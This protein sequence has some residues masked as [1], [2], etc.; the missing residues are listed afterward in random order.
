MSVLEET[1][2]SVGAAIADGSLDPKVSAGPIAALR[3]LA[4]Q[5]DHP[6]F[7]VVD[8]RLDNVSIPTYLKYCESL[9]LT[10]AGRVKLGEKKEA[11]GGKL[12]KLRS[13]PKPQTA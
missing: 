4:E 2:A 3:K 9:A 8:G 1:N 7:P 10:P 11:P 5:I 13:I 12:G 6:D